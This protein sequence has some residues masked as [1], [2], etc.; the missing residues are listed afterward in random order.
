MTLPPSTDC[1]DLFFLNVQSIRSHH[2]Q[3]EVLVSEIGQPT[4]L[5]LCETW[6]TINN[7]IGLFNLKSYQQILTCNR[8]TQK[9]GGLAFYVRE[10]VNFATSHLDLKLEH[11]ILSIVLNGKHLNICAV[12]RPPNGKIADFLDDLEDLVFELKS[13]RGSMVMCGDF[14]LNT[15]N[16]DDTNVKNYLDLLGSFDLQVINK[17][18]T[19]VRATQVINDIKWSSTCIDHFISDDDYEVETIKTTI[20][21]HFA[22]KLI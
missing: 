10:G 6:L 2:D 16:P 17:E 13:R 8:G 12:Y 5:V 9:G 15:I 22:I 4:I 20:S 14:N 7:P 3:L 19:R 1:H 21:D 18:P 11:F